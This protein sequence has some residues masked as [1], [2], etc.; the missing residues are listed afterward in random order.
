MSPLIVF[1]SAIFTVS[2]PVRATESGLSIAGWSLW[3]GAA[4]RML[5]FQG[6][7][8]FFRI[9]VDGFCGVSGSSMVCGDLA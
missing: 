2:A 3:G 4:E 7:R 5:F 9:Y 1:S 6:C 8:F